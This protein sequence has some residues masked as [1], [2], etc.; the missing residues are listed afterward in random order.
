MR[1]DETMPA[2]V[3]HRGDDGRGDAVRRAEPGEIGGVARPLSAEGEV[4]PADDRRSRR[5]RLPASRR[6]TPAPTAR[7]R[8]R[9]TGR[10]LSRRPRSPRTGR[11]SGRSSSARTAGRRGGRR[12]PGGGRTSRRA[13]AGRRRGPGPAPRR[14]PPG[15]RGG[16]RRS[17]RARRCRRATR[18][19]PWPHRRSAPS[20]VCSGGVPRRHP[21]RA[22]QQPLTAPV[23]RRRRGRRRPPGRKLT[24]R[25][26][27]IA[28]VSSSGTRHF[29]QREPYTMNLSGTSPRRPERDTPSVTGAA[30]RRRDA[31]SPRPVGPSAPLER[32]EAE[33]RRVAGRRD[34]RPAP[35]RAT[36]RGRTAAGR[37]RRPARRRPRSGTRA[38]RA[39]APRHRPPP[40]R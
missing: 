6:R 22:I 30:G 24:R 38:S 34:G 21:A 36:R 31:P 35:S 14:R 40:R 8:R 17:C 37:C 15:G 25:R 39:A 18:R 10:R 2:A 3:G 9:R 11:A 5:S 16:S 20:A 29:L 28:L 32:H 4:G 7:R 12:A 27:E 1:L 26:V 23:R 13:P 19:R 33:P